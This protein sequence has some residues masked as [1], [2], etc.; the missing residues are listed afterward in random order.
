MEHNCKPDI[1]QPAPIISAQVS[2]IINAFSLT[3]SQTARV[4]AVSRLTVYDWIK[5]EESCNAENPKHQRLMAVHGLASQWNSFG[6]GPLGQAHAPFISDHRSI[7]EVLSVD[8][9]DMTTLT[10]V[11]RRLKLLTDNDRDIVLVGEKAARWRTAIES[12]PPSME[13]QESNLENNL[14]AIRNSD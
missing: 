9:L 3:I 8:P 4:L 7:I 13:V 14:R 11:E 10:E 6:I 2:V 12:A 5:S 1:A